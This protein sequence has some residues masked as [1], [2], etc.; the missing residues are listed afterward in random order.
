MKN[1]FGLQ[2]FNICVVIPAF[3]VK[4]HI[5]KVISEIGPEVKSIIIVDDFCP[6]GT[7][8]YVLENSND[9]RVQVFFNRSNLGVG[10]S[11]KEGYRIAMNTDTDVVV[12]VDGDGQM[13]TSKITKLVAPILFGNADYTKGN[14]FSDVAD[15]RQMPKIRILGNLVLSFLTKVS[16][17][18]W[19]VFDPNNGFTAIEKDSL[20]KLQL[21]KIDNRYF[22]ESDMLFRLNI[23][24]ARVSDVSLP[25]IYG[26]EISNLSLKRVIFEFPI[27]HSRNL[28]KRIIY[29][30]YI[31]DFNLAS[32]ELP[33]GLCLTFFGLTLGTYSWFRGILTSVPTQMGTL[34]LVSMSVLAGLQLI[35]AFLSYDTNKSKN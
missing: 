2:D 29:T 22:F 1:D 10:G 16:S 28:F 8:K 25:A 7:G 13:D 31:R 19:Q 9:P 34:I 5:L 30:Y 17:G 14:R 12:K 20:A 35:L 3:R 4:S 26:D 24:G 33:L 23:L 27:K 11:V 15:V 21:E 6:D 32:I 18:Y